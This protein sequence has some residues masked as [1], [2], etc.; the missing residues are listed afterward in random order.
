MSTTTTK[1]N[2]G[3]TMTDSSSKTVTFEGVKST[4]IANIASRVEAINANMSDA[5][6]DTFVNADGAHV[7]T[8]GKAQVVT[9]E[10][11]VIYSAN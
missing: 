3:L 9:T 1:V 6:R 11:E 10:E 2:I 7:L 4:E 5:F 8:I